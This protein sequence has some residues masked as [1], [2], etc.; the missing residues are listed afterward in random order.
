MGIMP[1]FVLF[2]RIVRAQHGVSCTANNIISIQ[3]CFNTIPVLCDVYVVICL[4][5]MKGTLPR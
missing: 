2:M 5:I 4:G 1:A 3:K